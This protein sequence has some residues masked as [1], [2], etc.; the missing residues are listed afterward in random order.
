[1]N[2]FILLF[3]YII[4]YGHY[5]HTGWCTH[6][7]LLC[8]WSV[9]RRNLNP[10]QP[11][12]EIDTGKS[13]NAI[14]FQVHTCL[15]GCVQSVT[16]HPKQPTVLALGTYLNNSALQRNMTCERYHGALMVWDTDKPE[17][18]VVAPTSEHSH[19]EPITKVNESVFIRTKQQDLS[20]K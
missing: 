1:M 15:G 16:F 13:F 2:N 4:R 11:D 17:D 3:L 20:R 7:G 8:T 5:D 18:V 14:L 6:S 19:S 10:S 12:L 9:F